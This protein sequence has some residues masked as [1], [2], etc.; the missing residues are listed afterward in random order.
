MKKTSIFEYKDYKKF[1]RDRID[2]MPK[3]G[4]GQYTEIAK[5]LNIHNVVITQI[6]RGDKELSL[7]QALELS[8]YLELTPLERDYLFLLVQHNRAGTHKL[9][10]HIKEKMTE[11]REQSEDLQK[12]LVQD[13]KLSEETRAIFYSNW[14][15]SGVRLA[16]DIPGVDS[17]E[18]I[19]KRLGLSRITVQK[20]LEFLLRTGLCVEKN[21]KI[22]MGPQRVHVGNDS[23]LVSRHHTNWRLKALER[24]PQGAREDE[25]F[26][27]GPFALSKA[28]IQKIR[29]TLLETIEAATKTAVDSNSETLSCLNIDF[30]EY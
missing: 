23:I 15:F 8:N 20:V 13:K 10:E 9:K 26:F 18:E 21:G 25:L 11:L 12:R 29:K 3:Q 22:Q 30:F 28:A 4:Y 2:S 1:V 6:F 19:A 17:P 27:T 24:I 16:S 7:D 14:Y 5:R